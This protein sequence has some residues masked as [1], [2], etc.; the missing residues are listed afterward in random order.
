MIYP[1][2]NESHQAQQ[3]QP[4][5]VETAAWLVWI[6]ITFGQNSPG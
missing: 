2:P 4:P 5:S 6:D 3:S 1:L